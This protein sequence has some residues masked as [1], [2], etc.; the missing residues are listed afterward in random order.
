L[1]KILPVLFLV[2]AGYSSAPQNKTDNQT[3]TAEEKTETRR[4]K[5]RFWFYSK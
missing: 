3:A 1:K 2:L 5:E 4:S